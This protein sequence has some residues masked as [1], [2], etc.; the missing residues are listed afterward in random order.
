MVGDRKVVKLGRKQVSIRTEL[1]EVAGK[2]LLPM[3]NFCLVRVVLLVDVV[4]RMD[5]IQIARWPA[6]EVEA[7][8]GYPRVLID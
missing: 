8:K 6:V 4:V 7:G 2:N 1:M 3:T 5:P